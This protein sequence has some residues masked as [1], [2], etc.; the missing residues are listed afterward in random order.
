MTKLDKAV[1][2]LNR[3][4]TEANWKVF[5]SALK[6]SNLKYY[7][8][9]YVNDKIRRLKDLEDSYVVLYD[10]RQRVVTKVPVHK[11]LAKGGIGG[12]LEYLAGLENVNKVD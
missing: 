3:N 2:A 6:G 4:P 8:T 1:E 10:G 12:A 11:K 9:V 7:K 5:A